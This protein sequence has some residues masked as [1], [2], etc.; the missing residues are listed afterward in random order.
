MR[1]R[2]VKCG[3][4]K[5]ACV[6]CTSTGRT[7]DGYESR[8]VSRNRAQDP[9]ELARTEFLQTY[10]GNEALRN[11]RPLAPD[12]E[13]TE[14]E[15]KFFHRLRTAATDGATAVHGCDFASFWSRVAP[16]M[17]HKDEAV[18]HA[19]VA[20]GAAYQLSQSPA[21]DPASDGLTRE[22]LDVFTIQQYNLSISKL[23]RHVG[24]SSLPSIQ[25]TLV[26]CL[27]FICLETLRSNHAGAV[28]HL[29]NGINI[30]QSLEPS[31]FDFLADRNAWAVQ[32]ETSNSNI[33]CDMTDIVRLFGRIEY[34]AC[35]FV[36]DIRPVIAERGYSYRK[37]DDGSAENSFSTL[38]DARCAM[39][40]F[41]RDVMARLYET[42]HH[43]D[44]P[45]FWADPSQHRQQ[46]CLRARADRL[47][48]LV[49]QFMRSSSF[50]PTLL[51]DSPEF[52]CL[53]LSLL[54]FQCTLLLVDG[55]DRSM[56]RSRAPNNWNLDPQLVPAHQDP[57]QPGKKKG[58]MCV[59]FF[60][61]ASSSMA[62][63]QREILRLAAILH[64]SVVGTQL[65]T[66]SSGGSSSKSTSKATDS[67]SQS[68]PL[69]GSGLGRL[70]INLFSDAGVVGP[71]CLVAINAT[72]HDVRS[73]ALELL[74]AATGQE[75]GTWDES[76]TS[77][78]HETLAGFPLKLGK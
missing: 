28:S 11:M 52:F 71:L 6:R 77:T 68:Q 1:I 14:L 67:Q 55:I 49:S 23:Q 60:T 29:L 62:V 76:G 27:A 33:T 61:P 69:P 2:R 37:F 4:E 16:Q 8:A 21:Y 78:L 53:Y 3:E 34:S 58:I 13:G 74:A 65:R 43:A 17:G 57:L 42:G 75:E 41:E 24:S 48:A 40:C 70:H 20:L 72:D 18:K 73:C 51:P 7:C 54:H 59:D 64:K 44:N 36:S 56:S 35:F 10:Q 15:R 38:R 47:E 63:A 30:L 45:N 66:S 50:A 12:I 39:R 32:P 9:A 26:C 31:I 46:V 25:V 19:L 5:P 22:G